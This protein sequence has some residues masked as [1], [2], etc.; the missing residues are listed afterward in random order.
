MLSN[1]PLFSIVIP[2]HNRG[3]LL[4]NALRSALAQDFDDYEIVVVANGCSDN[5]RE[6]VDR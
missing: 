3:H 6:V 4:G 2:T 5:T 1:S